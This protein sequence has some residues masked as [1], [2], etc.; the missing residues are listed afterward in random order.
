MWDSYRRNS[1]LL[2]HSGIH[3][4]KIKGIFDDEDGYRDR[5]SEFTIKLRTDE[6]AVPGRAVRF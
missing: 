5:L 4:S 2:E 3:I 6:F 1:Y